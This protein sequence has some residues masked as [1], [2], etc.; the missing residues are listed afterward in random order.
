M[1]IPLAIA[2]LLS[3][4]TLFAG[5]IQLNLLG[6]RQLGM[7]HT[8]TGIALDGANLVFN[9]GSIGFLP[10]RVFQVAGLLSAPATTYLAASPSPD[11]TQMEPR[12]F[13]NFQLYTTWRKR[14][15]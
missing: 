3:S 11:L 14:D 2:L 12:V 7:G 9:P 8:G 5:G 1:R 15:E 6:C 10:K 4:G 13:S